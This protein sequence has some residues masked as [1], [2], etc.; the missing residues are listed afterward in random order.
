MRKGWIRLASR[1]QFGSQIRMRT[2]VRTPLEYCAPNGNAAPIL[3]VALPRRHAK[4]EE[5]DSRNSEKQPVGGPFP[6]LHAS[7]A[8]RRRQPPAKQP[9]RSGYRDDDDRDQRQVHAA[10]GTRFRG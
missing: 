4:A 2:S 9:P 8:L 6:T 3:R 1:F 7:L 10:F 5:R